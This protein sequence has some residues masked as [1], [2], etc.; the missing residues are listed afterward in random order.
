MDAIESNHNTYFRLIFN[1][2]GL[3]PRRPEFWGAWYGDTCRTTAYCLWH[4]PLWR[5]FARPGWEYK[6]VNLPFSAHNTELR[7]IKSP[8]RGLTNCTLYDLRRSLKKIVHIRY[9]WL[10]IPGDII[11][12]LFCDCRKVIFSC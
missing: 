9:I 10:I 1:S 8:V 4:S 3:N 2:T 7:R 11:F 6:T 5:D 12:E